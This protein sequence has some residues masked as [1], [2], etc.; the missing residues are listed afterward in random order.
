MKVSVLIATTLLLVAGFAVQAAEPVQAKPVRSHALLGQ[1][2]GSLYT[3]DYEDRVGVI[4]E[5]SHWRL[6]W[7]GMFHE[8]QPVDFDED[9]HHAVYITL[10][11]RP[12]GGYAVQVVRVY[13][14]GKH[15]VLEYTEHQPAPNQYVTQALTIPWVVVLLPRTDHLRVIASETIPQG[16][17][18]E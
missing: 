7:E 3:M 10:G 6:I 18:R 16:E 4:K 17:P 14:E 1:W 12:T 2:H 11:V 15:V 9:L 5:A 13:E 8:E